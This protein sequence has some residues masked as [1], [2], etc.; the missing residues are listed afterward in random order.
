MAINITSISAITK[1]YF[2]PS[3]ADEVQTSIPGVYVAGDIA[4]YRYQQAVTAAGAGCKAA[5]SAE[6]FIEG[7][8]T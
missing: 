4:D 5:M 3:L 1:R 2:F 6:E 7:L 8:N